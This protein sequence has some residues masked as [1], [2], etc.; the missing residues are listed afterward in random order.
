MKRGRPKKGFE[1]G[2]RIP[3]SLRVTSPIKHLVETAAES[4]GRSQSQEV[5]FRLERTFRDDEV[6]AELR[7]VRGLLERFLANAGGGGR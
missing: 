6:V 5:E 4:S 7:A 2:T 3:M 1:L